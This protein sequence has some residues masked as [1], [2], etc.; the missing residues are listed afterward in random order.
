[1]SRWGLRHS[2]FRAPIEAFTAAILAV[3]LLSSRRLYDIK[4]PRYL[5]VRVKLTKPSATE[6]F[7]V[8]SSRSY[9]SCSRSVCPGL[10]SSSS[11]EE[12]IMCRPSGWY[13]ANDFGSI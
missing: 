2:S 12:L 13:A 4:E 8:L 3:M 11:S 1:M 7:F 6:K 5:N 10:C 9:M